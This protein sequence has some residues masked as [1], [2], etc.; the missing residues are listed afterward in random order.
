M[1][2]NKCKYKC[3]CCRDFNTILYSITEKTKLNTVNGNSLKIA[4]LSGNYEIYN[5]IIPEDI[6]NCIIQNISVISS[7]PYIFSY[8]NISCTINLDVDFPISKKSYSNIQ[9]SFRKECKHIIMHEKN[10]LEL[11]RKKMEEKTKIKI[12]IN[13]KKNK[14]LQDRSNSKRQ[15]LINKNKNKKK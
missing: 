7:I 9:S 5:N 8:K 3:K 4:W 2:C 14:K 11:D 13:K 1:N 10:E 15:R 6:I 12:E